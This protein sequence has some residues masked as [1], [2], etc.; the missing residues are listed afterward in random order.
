MLKCKFPRLIRGTFLA[1]LLR[2]FFGIL[3]ELLF[4]LAVFFGQ[5]TAQRVVRFRLVDEGNESLNDLI[6]FR[7]GLP[8]L[9]RNDGQAD[10]AFF[11]HIGMIN[12]GFETDLGWLERIFCWKQDFDAES[13]LVERRF[14]GH[15][16][17]LKSTNGLHQLKVK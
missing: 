4:V 17:P 1:V 9:H 12:F 13:T 7:S 2:E 15:K 10:L 3:H 14:I 11:V 5:V 8:V 6:S 16:K